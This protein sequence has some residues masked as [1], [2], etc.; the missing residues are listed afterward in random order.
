M[1]E[2]SG[3]NEGTAMVAPG[4]P[5]QAETKS[6]FVE[7]IRAWRRRMPLAVRL[8]LALLFLMIGVIGGFIPILQGWVFVLAALWLIF[9]DHAE[10]I[11]EKFKAWF[12]RFRRNS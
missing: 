12:K 4:E 3:Q 9:P 7:K 1:T 8:P 5:S 10:Q 6:P 2:V 11:V